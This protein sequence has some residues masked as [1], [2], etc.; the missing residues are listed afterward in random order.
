[1]S[2]GH[3][4]RLMRILFIWFLTVMCV[5][6]EELGGRAYESYGVRNGMKPLWMSINVA[7]AHNEAVMVNSDKKGLSIERETFLLKLIAKELITR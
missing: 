6:D 3:G 5:I 1:M 7:I 4:I 2:A